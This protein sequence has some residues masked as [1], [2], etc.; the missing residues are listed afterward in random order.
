MSAVPDMKPATTG[1]LTDIGLGLQTVPQI[2]N[3]IELPLSGHLP[4]YLGESTLYRQGPGRFEITHSDG[5]VRHSPHWFDGHALL[6][7]FAIDAPNNK[8]SYRSKFQTNGLV[9]T[10]ESVPYDKYPDFTFA[11]SDPCKSIL[12]KFFQMWTK[13]PVDPETG[14]P[15]FPNVSVTVQQVPG[16]GMVLR[17]DANTNLTLD[18]ETLEAREFF[19]FKRIDPLL[20]GVMTA[21]HGHYD[22][23]KDEFINFT[24]DFGFGNQVEYH[25]FSIKSDG[26]AEILAT[27]TDV[28]VYIHSFATTEKYVIL[29]LW[30]AEL[31]GLKMMFNK[32]FMDGFHFN[33]EGCTKFVVI[34]REERRVVATYES[35]PFFCFHTINAF[36]TEDG[37]CI[38]LCRY[39]DLTILDNLLL[40]NMRYIDLRPNLTVTR[41][42]LNNISSAINAG[43]TAIQRVTETCLCDRQLELPRIHPG[44]LRKDY[45]YVYGI[46][47]EKS[48]FQL[49]TKI[50]LKTGERLSWSIDRGVTGE[51]IFVPDPNGVDE[52]DGCVLVVVL[53]AN[54]QTSSMFVLNAKDMTEMARAEVPQIVPLGFHGAFKKN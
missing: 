49:V 26:K 14:K 52:D 40:K 3:F 44:F 24:Y 1:Q 7:Q 2:P 23:E 8:V 51:P 33:K 4:S 31:N 34:S 30:P 28:P 39:E 12:G 38:D 22:A 19:S 6:H 20:K 35:D 17:T 29:C 53:D 9:R 18:E 43:P 54:K 10:M 27:F 36:D 37:I 11:P 32:S 41:Y 25:V 45:R 50:D 42:S 5:K 48:S 15:P 13:A 46:D 16:K 47:S 21:A